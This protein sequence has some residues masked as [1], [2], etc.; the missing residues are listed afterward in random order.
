MVRLS[1]SVLAVTLA[2]ASAIPAPDHH[3]GHYKSVSPNWILGFCFE[4]FQFCESEI[5]ENF[6]IVKIEKFVE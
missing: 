4:N 1:L 6:K 2:L 5:I 3:K